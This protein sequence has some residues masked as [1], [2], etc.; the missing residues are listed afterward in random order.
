VS[1]DVV[2]VSYNSGP[3][4]ARALASVGDPASV[5]VI[6]NRSSDDS[7]AVARGL[8][9]TV[10][11]NDQNLGFAAAANQGVALGTSELVLLLN[12]DAELGPD[13]L[14]VLGRA[15]DDDPGLAV[16]SPRIVHPD[17]SEE[18][19]WWPFPSA[20]GAWREAL[21]LHRLGRRS[22]LPPDDPSP[23]DPSTDDRPGFVIGACLLM[24]RDRFEA[25][26]GFDTRFWLYAE[27]SDL[28]RRLADD[29]WRVAVIDGAVA[30]HVGGASSAG[31]ETVTDEHFARGAELFVLKHS[32]RAA[33]VS[34]RLAQVVGS[35]PRAIAVRDPGR[36]RW[37][38]FRLTRAA[39]LLATHPTRVP[40]A[41]G[42]TGPTGVDGGAG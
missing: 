1:V 30:T 18:Q 5:L 33:L 2:V 24:R 34:L 26:G 41:P 37:H 22:G 31:I 7:V 12:P 42:P 8:G 25:L 20:A 19:V 40:P 21:G 3:H 15:L 16:V 23:D 13:T 39:R 14:E 28:C 17:G 9:A 38:R 4:L 27:E 36:R 35:A 11:A 6:D 29:G 32:G 10:V